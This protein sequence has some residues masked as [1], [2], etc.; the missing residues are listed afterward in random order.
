MTD[1]ILINSKSFPV[2]VEK[3]G[4]FVAPN[5]FNKAKENY[6]GFP[7]DIQK[8]DI[9]DMV[10]MPIWEIEDEEHT[11]DV[12]YGRLLTG[13]LVSG[14]EE[15]FTEFLNQQPGIKKKFETS[16]NSEL[17][18]MVLNNFWSRLLPEEEAISNFKTLMARFESFNKAHL[19]RD[20]KV[21]SHCFEKSRFKLMDFF[22]EKNF[23]YFNPFSFEHGEQKPEKIL[24]Q[25]KTIEQ[26]SYVLNK[27]GGAQALFDKISEPPSFI[28]FVKYRNNLHSLLKENYFKKNEELL[29]FLDEQY[30]QD[31]LN[32]LIS[33]GLTL[34]QDRKD[35]LE[36]YSPL[37]IEWVVK[38]YL[39]QVD[40]PIELPSG[41]TT[42]RSVLE[43]YEQPSIKV[44]LSLYLEQPILYKKP[45]FRF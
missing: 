18:L 25:S 33:H 10:G 16:K 15:F 21:I 34:E 19:E 8:V 14:G 22:L 23:Q 35:I 2:E 30:T 24:F 32:P 37:Y 17:M 20:S 41:T 31:G 36:A 6:K 39:N 12:S 40:E 4:C 45:S 27:F 43:K 28:Q 26:A 1:T 11:F 38:K 29:C 13:V 44:M 5:F 9:K 42:L 3:L 7:T